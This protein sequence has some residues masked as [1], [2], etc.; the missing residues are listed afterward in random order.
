MQEWFEASMLPLELLVLKS[1]GKFRNLRDL[2]E[3][4]P[5]H[6]KKPFTTPL[7]AAAAE[8]ENGHLQYGDGWDDG[9]SGY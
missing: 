3:L 1:G 5:D 9:L 2:R 4:T 7:P 8:E 6:R